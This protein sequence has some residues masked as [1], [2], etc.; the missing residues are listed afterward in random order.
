MLKVSFLRKTALI[1]LVFFTWFAMAADLN[2][3][4]DKDTLSRAKV[5]YEKGNYKEAINLL[6][7]FTEQLQSIVDQKEK[8]AGAFYWLAKIYY[9][10]GDDA[11]VR[12]YLAKAYENYPEFEAKENNLDFK[13]KIEEVKTSVA[14]VFYSKAHSYYSDSFVENDNQIDRLLRNAFT[15]DPAIEID[16][17]EPFSDRAIQV[18]RE[19]APTS[20]MS[21]SPRGNLRE[22][23]I[24]ENVIEKQ[25]KK[26]KKKFPWLLVAGVV[27]L[28]VAAFL[29]LKKK[30][31]N[32]YTLNVNVGNGINGNPG[33]GNHTYEEGTTVSYNYSL[34]NGYTDLNVMVDGQKTAASGT[35]TM[36]ANHSITATSNKVAILNV[37]ST[38][39]G[40]KIL[41]GGNDTGYLTDHTFTYNSPGSHHVKL[42]KL[43]FLE[44][45][46]LV[47]V[48]LG[49]ET[50][51]NAGLEKGLKEDF[52]ANADQ[53]F[54]W[55]WKP[56]EGGN[57]TVS[58]GRYNQYAR[59][60]AWNY[61][62]YDLNFAD[63]QY[64]VTVKMRRT[65]GDRYASNAILLSTGNN[66]RDSK[67]YLFCYVTIGWVSAWKDIDSNYQTGGGD[68]RTILNWTPKG[69]VNDGMDAWNTMKI[70][71]NGTNYS[72]Y[73]NGTRMHSFSDSTY[74]PGYIS[75]LGYAGDRTAS[76]EFDYV[77][78]EPGK[79]QGSVAGLPIPESKNQS[80]SIG[81]PGYCK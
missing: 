40:A 59:V 4:S 73:M 10:V 79:I 6:K 58:N 52:L 46:K 77:Y 53:S 33:S 81:H 44:F 39:V 51:I 7:E 64:T 76:M 57:W 60:K 24:S 42:Q 28:G 56:M 43:G 67:G 72:F 34:Q 16:F 17:S 20:Y 74:N 80:S 69:A 61:S 23:K 71:R 68:Y 13:D 27:V 41:I 12:T 35:I 31:K 29:L 2:F 19:L 49:Q 14:A 26:K 18:K 11:M 50:T 30:K 65:A 54:F 1:T 8:V 32:T 48:V 45:K 22:A 63:N 9:R 21:N 66:L 62:T 47:N 55:K 25:T 5:L 15:L 75:I 70:V 3:A 37:K 36:N 38:P 78:I